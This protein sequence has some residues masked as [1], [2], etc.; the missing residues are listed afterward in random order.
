MCLWF[1]LDSHV[2]AQ[3]PVELW[4]GV[5]LM[6]QQS[7]LHTVIKA[8]EL[9]INDEDFDLLSFLNKFQAQVSVTSVCQKRKKG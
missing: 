6:Q 9:E 1:Q 5:L 3:G 8:S 2:L 4:L 7:S